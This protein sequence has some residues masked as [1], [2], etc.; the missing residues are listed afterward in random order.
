MRFF[1]IAFVLA[2]AVA[3]RSTAAQETRFESSLDIVPHDAA[4]YMAT[5]NHEA[6]W[7]QFTQSAA[8]KSLQDSPINK[9]M[10]AAYRKR[11]RGFEDMGDNPFRYYLEAYARSM[12]SLTG[13]AVMPYLQKIFKRELFFYA[14]QELVRVQQAMLKINREMSELLLDLEL[15]ENSEVTIEELQAIL[16]ENLRDLKCPTLMVGALVDEPTDFV[17]L[18]DVADSLIQQGFTQL[19]DADEVRKFYRSESLPDH[20]YIAFVIRGEEL[21][22]ELFE[23]GAN[24]DDGSVVVVEMLKE[25]LFDREFAVC[26]AVRKNLLCVSVGP[27]LDHVSKA[28]ERA[29]LIDHPHMQPI[30]DARAAGRVL[31]QVQFVDKSCYETNFESVK[32]SF[33]S[34]P[35][36]MLTA[37]QETSSELISDEELEQLAET[38]FR[39]AEELYADFRKYYGAAGDS[40]GY[41]AAH[42]QGLE[43]YYYYH[44]ANPV[45]DS[46]QPLELLRHVGA[47]PL[48]FSLARERPDQIGY[49]FFRKWTGKVLDYFEQLAPYLIEDERQADRWL[50]ALNA[51]RPI[52]RKIDEVTVTKIAPNVLGS[53]AGVVLGVSSPEVSWHAEMPAAKAPLPLALPMLIAKV[54]DEAPVKEGFAD[55]HSLAQELVAALVKNLEPDDSVT[56][57]EL[58]PLQQSTRDGFECF[59]VP[60]PA[61]MGFAQSLTPHAS[62]RHGLLMIGLQPETDLRRADTAPQTLFGPAAESKPAM[63]VHW[64]DNRAA[65]DLVDAWNDYLLERWRETQGEIQIPSNGASQD[66]TMNEEDIRE[67]LRRLREFLRCF[68]GFSIR[69]HEENGAQITH[70]LLRFSDL[71]ENR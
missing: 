49:H 36:A 25:L 62:V 55:Y 16:S 21:P 26:L 35:T 46:S 22:W 4:L 3:G 65:M 19:P 11:S 58:P 12:D 20:R 30:R 27:N 14:D 18:I 17:S 61:D 53:E 67:T 57:W 43:G 56:S 33:A 54:Q 28:G 59:V 60:I 29:K 66:L 5:M 44:A 34:L 68:H 31:H 47:R 50:D 6:L 38:M 48:F 51:L 39:D 13:K 37:L 40:V 2:L 64:F 63:A 8:L 52:L 32:D 1:L 24:D 69:A 7:T 70:F 9:K 71:P 45:L 41:I 10:R 42:E 23:E 15:M